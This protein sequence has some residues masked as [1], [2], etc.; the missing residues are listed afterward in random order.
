MN[1]APKLPDFLILGATKSG[2]TSLHHYLKQHPDVFLPEEKEIQFFIDDQLYKRGMGFYQKQYFSGTSNYGAVGEATPLYFHRPELVIPR[3]KESFPADSLKFV[4]L[5]RDP[6]KR[7]WSHYLHMVRLG[8]ETLDFERALLMEEKRLHTDPASWYS[9]FSD[10]LYGEL[11][12]QWFDAFSAERFLI[13][14]QD[15]FVR[16]VPLSLKKIFSFLG[17][18]DSVC[19]RDLS[20]KN[21][22]GQARSKRLMTLLMG[23]FPGANFIKAIVPVPFRRRL[24]MNLRHLNTVPSDH[25]KIMDADMETELRK[26]YVS[27][28]CKLEGLLNCSLEEWKHSRQT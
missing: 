25:A 17:V 4:L 23:R 15:E 8:A 1:R 13:L 5:L 11:L 2:T 20:I 21:E 7:A 16:D 12:E 6:V 18:D 24:G 14:T 9:Y 27:D 26:R 3:L 19:I 22:A 10:G 28:I